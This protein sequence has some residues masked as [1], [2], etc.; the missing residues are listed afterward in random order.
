MKKNSQ[1]TQLTPLE[2]A[3][4]RQF[5]ANADNY[6]TLIKKAYDCTAKLQSANIAAM[7]GFGLLALSIRPQIGYGKFGEWLSKTLGGALSKSTAYSWIK[8]AEWLIYKIS[9]ADKQTDII[10]TRIC[11]FIKMAGIKNG[12]EEIFGDKK[13]S[14]E[15]VAY[16]SSGLPFKTFLNILK[17][18]NAAALE[19]EDEE[20]NPEKHLSKKDLKALSGNN[21]ERQINF[22]DDLFDDV[23]AVTEI[24]RQNDPGFLNLTK[25]ELT[26]YGNYLVNEGKTVLQL[27][28]NKKD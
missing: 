17:T 15:F 2:T 21:S 3:L 1:Q 18:A 23:R 8:A 25:D 13:L 16:V 22:F 19:A 4:Q 6:E 10:S 5:S 27:A 11:D 12:A 14:S 7:V 9:V 20:N 26:E 24:K 28:A